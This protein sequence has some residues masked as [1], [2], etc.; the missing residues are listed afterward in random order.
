MSCLPRLAQHR[1]QAVQR[2]LGLLK[3]GGKGGEA[4]RLSASLPTQAAHGVATQSSHSC[5]R[6]CQSCLGRLAG[7]GDAYCR[8]VGSTALWA[9]QCGA[10][11]AAGGALAVRLHGR[12]LRPCACVQVGGSHAGQAVRR[13]GENVSGG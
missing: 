3:V 10:Q 8:A 9:S 5:K 13:E 7:G 1:V 4:E 6:Q 11:A 12:R 2:V